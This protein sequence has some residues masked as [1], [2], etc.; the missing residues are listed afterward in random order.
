MH[1]RTF[2]LAASL[3]ANSALSYAAGGDSGSPSTPVD[4]VL[5][6]AN[7]AIA[8]QDWAAAQQ[9][10]K[11]ALASDANNADYH[12]LYAFSLR[13]APHPDMNQV[14]LHYQEALRID[15]R[16]RG[17]HEYIGEAYLMVDNLTK[18]REHL[19][20]LDKLCFFPCNEYTDLKQAVAK[21]Q[22]K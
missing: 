3:L 20:A 15:P 12:N 16:H 14:F 4:P 21:Y 7:A 5:E 6:Q 13:K 18:A 11:Q 2:I 17:A 22:Q 10:L 19:A 9:T 8:K 1:L